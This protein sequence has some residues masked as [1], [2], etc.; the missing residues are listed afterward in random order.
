[1][2]AVQV[3]QVVA[4]LRGC[5]ASSFAGRVIELL[6][7]VEC[8]AKIENSHYQDHEQG[9]GDGEFYECRSICFAERRAPRPK[10]RGEFVSIKHAL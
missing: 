2:A 3:A 10:Q 8:S 7:K 1:M 6:L 5:K 4:G 9:Q